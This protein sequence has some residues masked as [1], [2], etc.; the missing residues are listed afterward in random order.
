METHPRLTPLTNTPGSPTTPGQAQTRTTR[1]SL[2]Q[3]QPPDNAGP[4][5][6]GP[7]RGIHPDR[8]GPATAHHPPPQT[9]AQ[10]ANTHPWTSANRLTV[11]SRSTTVQAPYT[12][13]TP[14]TCPASATRTSAQGR[15]RPVHQP[16]ST[17]HC[18][19]TLI[20]IYFAEA[21]KV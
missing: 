21:K 14:R 3:S 13:L 12:S 1:C 20:M 15:S 6:L 8:T 4:S 10:P 16:A 9:K 5:F 2:R 17:R 19:V 7:Y 18:Q 11:G